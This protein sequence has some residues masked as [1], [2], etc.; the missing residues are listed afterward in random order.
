M[1]YIM[2]WLMLC[3]LLLI[4]S[5][6]AGENKHHNTT[7]VFETVPIQVVETQVAIS[8][9]SIKSAIATSNAM[10]G[11]QFSYG[12][13]KWQGS[14][15]VGGYDGKSAIAGGIAKRHNGILYTSSFGKRSYNITANWTF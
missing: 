7:I 11:Q 1:K 5:V 8:N 13:H 6:F 4:N 9:D 2:K 10:S 15:A 12:V 3:G 14:F